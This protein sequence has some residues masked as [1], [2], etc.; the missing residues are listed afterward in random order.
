[1]INQINHVIS[2]ANHELK[3]KESIWDR[4]QITNVILPEMHDLYTHLIKNEK[5]FK[6]GHRQRMLI[7]TYL[8]TDSFEELNK[9][10]LG[11]EIIELQ[12]MYNE[13]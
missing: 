9:T 8:I 2:L 4:E 1:M 6:Y 13:L 11:K 10:E 3:K 7:S 5:Y 12:H